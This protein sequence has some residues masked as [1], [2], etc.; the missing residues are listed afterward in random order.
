MTSTYWWKNNIEVEKEHLLI[1]KTIESNSELIIQKISEIHSYE[2]P[3]CI[4]IPITKGSE[5]YLHWISSVLQN[6]EE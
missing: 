5:K 1:I 4:R 6:I 2:N 3:E